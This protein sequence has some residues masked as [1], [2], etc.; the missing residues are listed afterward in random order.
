MFHRNLHH[1][2]PPVQ[3]WYYTNKGKLETKSTT[4]IISLSNSSCSIRLNFTLSQI[5]IIW[6]A[7]DANPIKK[8]LVRHSLQLVYAWRTICI[9]D[10]LPIHAMPRI[11]HFF[12]YFQTVDLPS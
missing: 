7:N 2:T 8:T 10:T 6:F 5:K 4:S 11:E 9:L 12:H 1:Q 3:S